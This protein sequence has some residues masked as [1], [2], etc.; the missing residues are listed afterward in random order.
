MS[1]TRRHHRLALGLAVAALATLSAIAPAGA[2]KP[3]RAVITGGD[4]WFTHPVG[5]YEVILG[6]GE[7]QIGKRTYTGDLA[8]NVQPD[9]RSMPAAG[10]CEPGSGLVVIDGDDVDVRLVSIGQVCAHHPQE[11]ISVVVYSFTGDAST[12]VT[13]ARKLQLRS[14]FLDIRMALDGRASVFATAA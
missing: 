5:W 14:G 11:P 9:D 2:A 8:A 4:H 10:E 1:T 7:V 13:G 3:P 6:P 12:E